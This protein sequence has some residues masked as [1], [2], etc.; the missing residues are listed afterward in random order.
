MFFTT[1]LC[2][3]FWKTRDGCSH[4][5]WARN[6]WTKRCRL[7]TISPSCHW[8]LSHKSSQVVLAKLI[9]VPHHLPYLKCTTRCM[10]LQCMPLVHFQDLWTNTCGL[11]GVARA[12]GSVMHV[13]QSV[14]C[15]K[16]GKM[17]ALCWKSSRMWARFRTAQN[18]KIW[19]FLKTATCFICFA[20]CCCS[21]S[22]SSFLTRT[23]QR[24]N[25]IYALSSP[26]SRQAPSSFFLAPITFCHFDIV[27]MRPLASLQRW[28]R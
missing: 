6:Q 25:C 23:S 3:S 28:E 18:A 4:A 26:F 19:S 2:V 12:F 5:G 10:Y 15:E 1:V 7:R 8:V 20:R 14:K 24:W 13:Q 27:T 11:V 9:N 22:Y 21:L 16:E 17:Y